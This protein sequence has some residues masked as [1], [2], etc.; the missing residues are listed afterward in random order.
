MNPRRRS[1]LS[2]AALAL[3]GTASLNFSWLGTGV[4]WAGKGLLNPCRSGLPKRLAEHPLVQAAWQGIDTDQ[5]WDCHVHIA[6]TGDSGSGISLSPQM[7][8]LR[9]PLQFAQRLFY[10]NAGCARAAVGK[11]DETYVTRLRDLVE[12]L[13]PGVKLMLFAFDRAHDEPGRVLAEK[14]AFYVPNA[15]A[16]GLARRYPQHFEWVASIHPY[17]P[18]AIAALETAAAEGA[19]A[20]KWLPA[21][22]GIDPASPR[23]DDFYLALARLNLPLISHAGEERAVHGAGQSA[24]G[25]PLKL[26][27]PLD[28]GVRLVVAHCASIGQDRDLDRGDQ[29]PRTSSFALFS[30]LMADSAYRERLFA[31]ISAVTQR[32]RSPALVRTILER[33]DWHGRLLN[34]SDYPLPGVMPLFAPR[35]FARAGLLAAEAV[36][37]L[38]EI[39]TY[40]PLLFDFVLK[41]LLRADGRGLPA[42]VFE[43]RP[44]FTAAS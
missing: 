4:A 6:G 29:G 20:V 42:R 16:R 38:D 40:N 44:F 39:Q 8:S 32:N 24:F 19:R 15:Y 14:S 25:N 12:G 36:P 10:L 33:D 43:T 21:A 37:V 18:D 11:V 41:R 13:P 5:V 27:R 2:S 31:D 34:G 22:M 1:L 35:K 17:R 3:F 7:Q 28:L 23:C 26:R 30:R 9:H